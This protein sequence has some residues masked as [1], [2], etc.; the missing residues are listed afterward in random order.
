MSTMS[1]FS[2]PPIWSRRSDI[3]VATEHPLV[4][5]IRDAGADG[6]GGRGAARLRCDPVSDQRNPLQQPWGQCAAG[7]FGLYGSG[8][9]ESKILKAGLRYDQGR[10]PRRAGSI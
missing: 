7:I 4:A 5:E 1:A 10:R 3:D 8:V 6:A 9:Q 2:I